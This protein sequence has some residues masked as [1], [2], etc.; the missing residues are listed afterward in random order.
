MKTF[1]VGD[2]HGRCAQL[3]N[4]LDMLP[5]DPETDKLVF[6]GEMPMGPQTIPVRQTYSNF[7]ENSFEWAMEAGDGK[8]NW[9]PEMSLKYQRAVEAKKAAKN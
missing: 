2:I 7:T 5:R 3:L 9:K 6:L 4:L 1:I 8:G